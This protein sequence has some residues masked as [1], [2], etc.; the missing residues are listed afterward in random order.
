M[1]KESKVGRG[2]RLLALGVTLL[3]ALAGCAAVNEPYRRAQALA[4]GE[5]WEGA[6]A[7]YRGAV[8]SEP[9]NLEFR[10]ALI[11]VTARAI[12]DLLQQA[13][14][15]RESQPA[16]SRDLYMRVLLIEPRNERAAA[17]VRALDALERQQELMREAARA[18][19]A[20][21][22]RE[23]RQ[24]LK[25]LLDEAPDHGP[26][27]RLLADMDAAARAKVPSGL[28]QSFQKRVTL[29]FR[30][31]PLRSVFEVL[32]R[33][34]GINFIFD[35]D[36]RADA[37]IS[38]L[39]R[40]IPFD[41]A[42]D[43]IATAN[44]LGRRVV[45]SNTLLIYSAQP[46]KLR[47]YQDQV[48]RNFFLENADAKQIG[49]LLR[50]VLKVRDIFVDERR[51]L[52]VLRDT[53]EV[54][55][56]AV[57]LVAAH[58]QPEPEVMLEVEIL[59]VKHTVLDELGIRFPDQLSF[60]LTSPATVNAVRAA[61]GGSIQ[62]SGLDK[63]L[64]LN[65]KHQLGSTNLLANPRIRV[66]NKEKAKVHIGD[67]VPVI[68]STISTVAALTTESVSYLDVGI[69][70]EVEPA[71]QG[72]DV[73][74]KVSLEVSSVTSTVK[75]NSGSTAFQLGTRNAATTLT[76][77]DGETQV[78]A[79]LIQRSERTNSSRFPGLGDLPIL[80]R[81]FASDSL[82][83]DK[84]EVLLS[85]TPRITRNIE[86]PSDDLL[87]FNAGPDG[88]RPIA[89]VLTGAPAAAAGPANAVQRPGQGGT[90]PQVLTTPPGFVN[91]PPAP[92]V[93]P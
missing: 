6:I 18:Q 13:G 90:T 60:G 26:A 64:I 57:K 43:Q 30:D 37:R 77:R 36:L 66:R 11:R 14:E 35:R 17:G 25:Q 10:A 3:A 22:D 32:S 78:L 61:G 4:A 75:T 5:E 74:I 68:T 46:Q 59:E 70:L 86:R 24:K 89:P 55:A 63:A 79:G 12:A 51:N 9:G 56:M 38:I 40:D 2:L 50:T 33:A 8:R 21:R 23:A 85:I 73:V 88:G 91:T 53:P 54:V 44:G 93:S 87:E 19:A 34:S 39:V 20:G 29:E 62:V 67:R 1:F 47:E 42:L 76:L 27:R 41:E 92:A 45:N 16:R 82:D 58:D 84:T 65:L 72:N 69:K 71:I 81:L 7:N 48:V 31:A 28:D 52:V 80:G 15:V 83:G 49:S